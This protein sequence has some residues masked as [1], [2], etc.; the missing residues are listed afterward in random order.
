MC[1][2]PVST[3]S[4]AKIF[5]KYHVPYF[6]NKGYRED[7]NYY[8]TQRLPDSLELSQ[9]LQI[10][11]EMGQKFW[12]RQTNV[13]MSSWLII[14]RKKRKLLLIWTVNSRVEQEFLKFTELKSA[15][16]GSSSQVETIFLHPLE[17]I[18]GHI[19]KF[20]ID[21]L[22]LVKAATLISNLMHNTKFAKLKVQRRAK[23]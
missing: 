9:L 1:N 19:R 16:F 21:N 2:S 12:C 22:N 17:H 23:F 3:S 14:Y 8:S 13:L 11:N 18:T 7:R 15:A 10:R 5:Q 20:S 6:Y 4:I